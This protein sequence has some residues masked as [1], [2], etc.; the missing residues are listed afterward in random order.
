MQKTYIVASAY[1]QA[2]QN[3]LLEESAIHIGTRVL[4]FSV[5]CMPNN[6][7]QKQIEFEIFRALS[8]EAFP[9]LGASFKSP[10]II[11][12]LVDF[13][14]E[15]RCYGI[16][17][18][19][20]PQKTQRDFEIYH[21]LKIT[22]TWI[23]EL[24]LPEGDVY[25]YNAGLS[26]AQTTFLRNH[27]TN[28]IEPSY[29]SNPSV[30]VYEALNFRQE[31]E[32]AV[33]DILCSNSQEATLAIFDLQSHA[34]F[35]E[36]VFQRY[37]MP[38]SLQNR[39]FDVI[40]Y[41]Y[42]S[43]LRF[44]VNPS[45]K[46]LLEMIACNALDLSRPEALITYIRHYKLE[47]TDIS[48]PFDFAV[49]SD[50]RQMKD[51]YALQNL[52]QEDHG[53]LIDF[54]V[55]CETLSLHEFI[56]T[57]LSI[58]S[59]THKHKVR[60]LLRYVQNVY[61]LI[62]EHTIPLFLSHIN[63]LTDSSKIKSTIKVVDANTVHHDAGPLYVLNLTSKNY[64]NLKSRTG[65]IDEK[66]CSS[67]EG[68]PTLETR[69]HFMLESKRLLFKKSAILNLS[70]SHAT[71]EGKSLE[72][73]YDVESLIREKGIKP[74]AWKISES[75]SGISISKRITEEHAR[76][77]FSPEGFIS[78]S[79]SSFEQYVTNPLDFFYKEGLKLSEPPVYELDGRLFGTLN[80]TYLEAAFNNKQINVW[81]QYAPFLPRDDAFLTIIQRLNTKALTFH[82]MILKNALESSDYVPT[83]FERYFRFDTLF[84]GIQFRGIIDRIDMNN[85]SILIIDYKSSPQS[86]SME[87]VRNGTQLQLLTYALI[88]R[89]LYQKPIQGVFYYGLSR[90]TI[91]YDT[92]SYS[93]TKGVKAVDTASEQDMHKAHALSGWFFQEPEGHFNDE[94][95]YSGLMRKKNDTFYIH[96][97]PYDIEAVKKY[98]TALY[99]Y[100]KDSILSGILD[101]DVLTLPLD[102][103]YSFK[104]GA[105]NNDNF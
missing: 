25:V 90:R 48:L 57:S 37:N 43:L 54:L 8:Q 62:D 45:T 85:D 28:F 59:E 101:A 71:Y 5:A 7:N 34:P 24:S 67:I 103:N 72:A 33:Q 92:Y 21:A 78:G 14:I 80:H 20:L 96:G 44:H 55:S 36:S 38:L 29:H 99:A 79:V 32:G 23:P 74:Q 31:L 70:F 50:L 102:P 51:L 98:L 65:I 97:K 105:E 18:S 84:A 16:S 6:Y 77:I 81:D 17:I 46:T 104:Q 15:L 30:R 93:K 35:I 9:L 27:M 41:Q 63:E 49:D 95:Y 76:G 4:P 10:Q 39:T 42:L 11:K 26:H 40:K 64:P 22:D 2:V 56:R 94:T 12:T 53:K 1:T 52:I 87:R 100:L 47:Y 83:D 88:A 69:N 86:L 89:I 68:Y 19:S 66:Y 61:T 75:Q 60:P 13:V 58:I 3:L 73:A 91:R 82:Q